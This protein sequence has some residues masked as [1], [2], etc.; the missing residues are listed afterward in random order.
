MNTSLHDHKSILQSTTDLRD[1]S[2]TPCFNSKHMSSR[3]FCPFP[4]SPVTD[5]HAA[6]HPLTQTHVRG[7]SQ[8]YF[9]CKNIRL[10]LPSSHASVDI[11]PRPKSSQIRR[12]PPAEPP[13]YIR[14]HVI[15]LLLLPQTRVFWRRG[16]LWV[17][18]KKLYFWKLGFIL[19]S[20]ITKRCRCSLITV[21]NSLRESD[22]VCLCVCHNSAGHFKRV[23]L[24]AGAREGLHRKPSG[25]QFSSLAGVRQ[26]HRGD[27]ILPR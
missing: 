8:K 23:K 15:S 12:L 1:K 3:A 4:I 26:R 27:S 25:G 2:R 6:P 18:F 16:R 19:S 17:Y 21:A 22:C 20:C 10:W 24:D 11:W 5:Q 9:V 14:C 7:H 13:A